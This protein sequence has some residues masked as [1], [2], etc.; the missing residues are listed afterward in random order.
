MSTRGVR[1]LE[2]GSK[3]STERCIIS[4]SSVPVS[5]VSVSDTVLHLFDE[6]LNGLVAL[7]L[8]RN[9]SIRLSCPHDSWSKTETLFRKYYSPCSASWTPLSYAQRREIAFNTTGKGVH[10]FVKRETCSTTPELALAARDAYLAR[11][12]S[13]RPRGIALHTQAFARVS[14]ENI[15]AV[16]S[17][18]DAWSER[19]SRAISTRLAIPRVSIRR[20]RSGVFAWDASVASLG[21]DKALKA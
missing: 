2:C 18:S 20:L 10:S 16:L 9:T 7:L 8:A 5:T 19:L 1:V 3:W 4:S 6:D 11:L 21:G 12:G 13:A 17:T 14:E 15:A